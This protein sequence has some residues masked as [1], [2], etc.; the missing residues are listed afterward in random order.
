MVPDACRA[1]IKGRYLARDSGRR[2][3]LFSLFVN[4]VLHD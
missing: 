2:A 3:A 1:V 4:V